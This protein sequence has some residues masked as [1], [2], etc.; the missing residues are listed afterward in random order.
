MEDANGDDI[1]HASL[2]MPITGGAAYGT[3]TQGISNGIH[4]M[5]ISTPPGL[6]N[7]GGLTEEVFCEI[8]ED[9]IL[10]ASEVG[11][12][13]ASIGC[14]FA[15]PSL[16]SLRAATTENQLA[17]LLKCAGFAIDAADPYLQIGYSRLEGPLPTRK[18]IEDRGLIAK[19]LCELGQEAPLSVEAGQKVGLWLNAVKEAVAKCVVD[20][21]E[22]VEARKTIKGE[23]RSI[24]TWLEASGQLLSFLSGRYSMVQDDFMVAT[25]L[26]S[27]GKEA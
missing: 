2:S 16:A 5:Q 8:I 23:A 24:P 25:Q 15:P 20:L 12:A 10:A 14:H 26:S 11:Q 21:P 22:A 13:N 17:Q 1:L 19:R 27:I 3:S 4:A 6:Q 9:T 7:N 18:V